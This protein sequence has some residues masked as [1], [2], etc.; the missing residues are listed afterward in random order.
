MCAILTSGAANVGHGTSLHCKL[1][2]WDPH[3]HAS[4]PKNSDLDLETLID[5]FEEHQDLFTEY[6]DS[7][8]RGRPTKL[9][10]AEFRPV[11]VLYRLKEG[12]EVDSTLGDLWTGRSKGMCVSDAGC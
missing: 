2:D 11:V 3:T 10:R 9:D 8:R 12:R 4:W 6:I 1:S 5:S 7:K